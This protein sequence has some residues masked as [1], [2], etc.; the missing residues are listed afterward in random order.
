MWAAED[1]PDRK[2]Q[3]AAAGHKV[4]QAI[5]LAE[6]NEAAAHTLVDQALRSV[7]D[8]MKYYQPF[9]PVFNAAYDRATAK[10]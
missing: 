6:T 8:S 1:E 10:R 4:R 3:L 9:A 2:R 5:E 7:R